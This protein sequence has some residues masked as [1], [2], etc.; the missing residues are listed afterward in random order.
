MFLLRYADMSYHGTNKVSSLVSALEM[1]NEALV[2]INK[3]HIEKIEKLEEDLKSAKRQRNI[4]RENLRE[5]KLEKN[6]ILESLKHMEIK[7]VIM[8]SYTAEDLKD[9]SFEQQIVIM[10]GAK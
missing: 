4:Y 6:A 3:V 7:G 5:C 9:K 2:Y 8:A 10:E 1:K